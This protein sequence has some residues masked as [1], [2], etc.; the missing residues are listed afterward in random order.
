LYTI[1]SFEIR[2]TDIFNDDDI[3][4]DL[5]FVNIPLFDQANKLK[6]DKQ[7]LRL[8]KGKKSLVCCTENPDFSASIL[9]F[10]LEV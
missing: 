8:Y 1:L 2:G 5:F 6:Q 10:E 4:N 9:T 3:S 7:S